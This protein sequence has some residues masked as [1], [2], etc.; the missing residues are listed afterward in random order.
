MNRNAVY[1][2]SQGEGRRPS[3]RE[4]EAVLGLIGG[5]LKDLRA[6]DG[7]GQPTADQPP[8]CFLSQ[9]GLNK[10]M[11]S[12]VLPP[13]V[14]FIQQTFLEH[15]LCT[16]HDAKPWRENDQQDT[17][18][19]TSKEPQSRRPVPRNLLQMD[20]NLNGGSEFKG[21]EPWIWSEK[22]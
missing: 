6:R 21:K 18:S 5:G 8:F 7:G 14:P 3:D 11:E 15:M 13:I 12:C 1:S 22:V 10:F 17:C 20:L 19:L 16:R 4:P 2:S 9:L